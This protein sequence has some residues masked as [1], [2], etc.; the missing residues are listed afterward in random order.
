MGAAESKIATGV[1]AVAAA[2]DGGVGGTAGGSAW[3]LASLY[4]G[5]PARSRPSVVK[6]GDIS[7]IV[8]EGSW[9]RTRV[10][11]P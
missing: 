8:V 9:N 1:A 3:R 6:S 4:L 7:H 5:F 11:W 2:S 10:G